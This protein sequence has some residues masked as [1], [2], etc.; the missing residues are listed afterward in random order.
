MAYDVSEIVAFLVSYSEE[1]VLMQKPSL[2][3]L[4]KSNRANHV[5][6]WKS[7][8][9]FWSRKASTLAVEQRQELE[10]WEFVLCDMYTLESVAFLPRL[11]RCFNR[12]DSFSTER[13][14]AMKKLG[15]QTLAFFAK[16]PI[17]TIFPMSTFSLVF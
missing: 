14:E 12:M 17:S 15:S 11:Q 3:A 16:S 10:D 9:K 7:A 8:K 5:N 1:L 13:A 6:E 2:E 4:F